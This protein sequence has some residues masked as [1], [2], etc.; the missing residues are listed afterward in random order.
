MFILAIF[1]MLLS[2][3]QLAGEGTIADTGSVVPTPTVAP[4]PTQPTS[5]TSG[6]V[7]VETLA[8]SPIVNATNQGL[9]PIRVQCASNLVTGVIVETNTPFTC[10]GANTDANFNL[11]LSSLS[12]GPFTLSA[13]FS[14]G[15][16][17]ISNI[18]T[19]DTVGPVLNST[20]LN[21]SSGTSSLYS[22]PTLY[23]SS[24]QESGSGVSQY[25]GQI[26]KISNSSVVAS[27]RSMV[28]G[29]HMSSLSLLSGEN[30]VYELKAIDNAGNTGATVVSPPWVAQ[31]PTLSILQTANSGV[32][33]NTNAF[34]YS[35]SGQ[36]SDAGGTVG[37][38]VT[39]T[40]TV[41]VTTTLTCS[42]SRTWTA[43]LDLSTLS[44]GSLTVT[45][46]FQDIA[47]NLA[48]PATVNITKQ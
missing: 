22:A 4:T 34:S 25:L 41:S 7:L 24:A 44:V 27:W 46:T 32:V 40:L 38:T 15:Q 31:G 17:V 9:F 37:L 11:N 16:Y 2:A 14:D 30:Y 48:T 42:A 36:C 5:P 29:S 10:S 12:D 19:K 26:K 21:L 1:S 47:N 18:I 13:N 43:N 6:V 33:D 20:S 3:C 45:A 39:D 23:F 35:I 28:S 8:A